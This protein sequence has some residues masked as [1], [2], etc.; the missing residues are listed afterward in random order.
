MCVCAYMRVCVYV[1][2]PILSRH[3]L[4]VYVCEH[5]RLRTHLSVCATTDNL[6]HTCL[7]LYLCRYNKHMV[8]CVCVYHKREI[9][10]I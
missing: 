10:G 7:S 2:T 5:I 1:Y 8:V 6:I 4:R 3:A 9:V